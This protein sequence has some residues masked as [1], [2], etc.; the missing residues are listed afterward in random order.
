MMRVT[1]A[2]AALLAAAGT[3]SAADPARG[4]DL[5]AQCVACHSLDGE[6][7]VGPTLRGMIGRRA[8]ALAEFRYS[9]AMRRATLV[10]DAASLE[11]FLEDPQAV[12]RGNRMPF[13]GVEAAQDRADIA[14]YLAEAGK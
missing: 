9:P 7:G 4:R 14:A 1:I 2:A 5:Y 6:N 10:W 12:V 11:R 8:G 13:A 3:A